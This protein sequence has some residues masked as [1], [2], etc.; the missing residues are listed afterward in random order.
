MVVMMMLMVML[1][2]SQTSLIML[3]MTMMDV[4]VLAL[5]MLVIVMMVTMIGHDNVQK[6]KQSTCFWQQA[7]ATVIVWDMR[8]CAKTW[9]NRKWK[10]QEEEQ[11]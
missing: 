8:S 11:N 7:S 10:N 1:M 6:A 4:I 3:M 9:K 5:M 2:L